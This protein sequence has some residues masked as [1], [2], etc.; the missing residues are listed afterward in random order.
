M[1]LHS[2][3]FAVLVSVFLWL[4]LGRSLS[5]ASLDDINC[6]KSIKDSLKD[7]FNYLSSSWDFNNNTEGF[8][9]RFMGVDCWHPDENRVLNIKLSDMELKGEFPAGIIKC[10]SLT[11]LDLSSNKL[12]GSIPSNISELLPFVT[13][14]D[15]SS[16]NFSGDIPKGLANCSFLN[17]LKLDHNKL[18]G[19]IPAELG[20]L[21]RMKTFSIANNLLRGPIP[22]F[23]FSLS[24]DSFANNPGLCGKPLDPCQST[25]KG[26]KTVV[27]AGA[28]AGG[29]T[30]AAI[31]VGIGML[32]YFRKVSVKRKKD[33]DPEGNKW[34]KSL[35]GAKVIKVSVFE[36][37]VSK[38]RLNDLLKATNSFSKNNI[39]G[40]GRTGTMYKGVLED[41]T[42]LMIKR[43]Q[44]SQHS[45]K[46]FSYEMATLGSV[47]HRNLVP[48]LGFCVAKKERLLVYKYMAN[49]SLND[50]LHLVDD[51]KKPMEW[52]LR[53]KISI[54]A[55]RGF[56]WL[57]HNCNPCIIH[58]NVSSRCILL[59]AD[60][61]PKISDFGLARLMNPID[62]HL[63]TFVNG[64]F[65]D[66]GYVAPEYTRTLVAT[67]KGDVYSFGIVLLEL[68][69]GERPTY[70]AK[71]PESFK[72]NL[73]EWI[74]QL[75][76]DGKL[77]DAIDTSLVGKGVDNEL[78][79][80]LKVACN[81]V[82]P[83][84]KE[85]PT[86]FEVYQLLR[87]IGERYHFITEDEILMPS[88]TGDTD[89]L[90]ELIVAR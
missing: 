20:L 22:I 24:A 27:I 19:Q 40:S 64:E 31:G 21:S 66:L 8:I 73:V 54:G 30:V 74:T 83:P 9:C 76:N 35:K 45:D 63:S 70:V 33:D 85:R 18:T 6:L 62:T 60:F 80:F 17:I 90:E 49:G 7:P 11:G 59:D 78:F 16:N 67:P 79:Q 57:H 72:G 28:A 53:L 89:Y 39:I 77:H 3:V 10:K 14:L 48:L 69:T 29:V 71:A 43:L 12:Y 13:S 61:E 81:C 26:G 82:L 50:N 1:V 68:V 58:R 65:G 84:A 46:E 52:S 41:G 25:S 55:A 2:R 87:A 86:M 23:R 38:M 51:A 75:S 36:K 56:A 5:Y 44:D 37:S 34:A 15:L 88:D 4:L 32:V 47:K 42:S